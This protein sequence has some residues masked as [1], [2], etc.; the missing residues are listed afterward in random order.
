[1]IHKIVRN[2]TIILFAAFSM[3]SF[4][5][6]VDP[7][8]PDFRVIIDTSM[9]VKR[10]DL[11]SSLKILPH[12]I[13]S[14][15]MA[16]IIGYSD[17][18]MELIAPSVVD[19][20][21]R[22]RLS[23]LKLPE[24]RVLTQNITDTIRYSARTWVQKDRAYNR[25]IILIT[26]G[27]ISPKNKGNLETEVAADL[28]DS[29]VPFMKERGIIL[30]VINIGERDN[31]AL[32]EAAKMTGGVYLHNLGKKQLLRSL[33]AVFGDSSEISSEAQAD[34]NI[35]I[36]AGIKNI[37]FIFNKKT[38]T[39]VIRIQSPT[40][41]IYQAIQKDRNIKW[42]QS[43]NK[44]IVT[45]TNPKEGKWK[46]I[47]N[48]GGRYPIRTYK[49]ISLK[50]T[51][52]TQE[53]YVGEKIPLQISVYSDEGLIQSEDFFNDA[54]MDLFLYDD[55]ENIK[56]LELS[57]NLVRDASNVPEGYYNV[58]LDSSIFQNSK[59]DKEIKAYLSSRTVKL[60]LEEKLQI[61]ESPFLVEQE[62][63]VESNGKKK[64]IFNIKMISGAIDEY[65]VKL[66]AHVSDNKGRSFPASVSLV[67][68]SEW[69]FYLL[70]S[71]DITRYSVRLSATCKSKSGRDIDMYVDRLSVAVPDVEIPDPEI[72][73][74]EILVNNASPEVITIEKEKQI[75]G[76]DMAIGFI[77]LVIINI[78]VPALWFGAMFLIKSLEN[79]ESSELEEKFGKNVKAES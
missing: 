36:E 41:K 27:M 57:D 77:L 26:S 7:L 53:Y 71:K 56:T 21:W 25:N 54:G 10:D 50:L 70:P 20:S 3:S 34:N 2:I 4:A 6:N 74:K 48:V 68:A 18:V 72:I 39:S 23:V 15:A 61:T 79:K 60:E 59:T 11:E 45:I 75:T 42:L 32:S 37:T 78:L 62:T 14:G 76:K 5:Y 55:E 40:G 1:M 58:I 9:D 35:A 30:N 28:K 38:P 67:K 33:G 49:N 17:I 43:G 12:K 24:P 44:E 52:T 31:L 66:T 73:Y 69:K 29:L 46:I 63:E 22:E 64:L 13:P 65:S 19:A 51:S 47:G 8:L 16:G